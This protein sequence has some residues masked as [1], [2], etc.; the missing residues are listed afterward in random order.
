[1]AIQVIQ[2][3]VRWYDMYLLCYVV[4]TVVR[5]GTGDNA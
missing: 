5:C 4:D 3:I 1:M 2:W